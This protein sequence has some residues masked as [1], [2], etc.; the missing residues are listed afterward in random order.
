MHA[1]LAGSDLGAT[2]DKMMVGEDQEDDPELP[3]FEDQGDLDDSD[4]ESGNDDEDDKSIEDDNA[5]PLE[6]FLNEEMDSS[7]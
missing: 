1:L 3:D 6:E 5:D 7:V 4:N 2:V